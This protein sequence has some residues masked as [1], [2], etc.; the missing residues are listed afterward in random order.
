MTVSWTPPLLNISRDEV[1]LWNEAMS[2]SGERLSFEDGGELSFRPTVPPT[3]NPVTGSLK[4]V[5]FKEPLLVCIHHFPFAELFDVELPLADIE[6]LPSGLRAALYEG[7]LSWICD[8]AIPES[9]NYWKLKAVEQLENIPNPQT[10]EA[11]W[12]DFD[13]A[14]EGEYQIRL[15]L[16][17][18]RMDAVKVLR[19]LTLDPTSNHAILA[20]GVK[21]PADFIIGLITLTYR[22]LRSLVSGSVVVM[23][24]R[25]ADTCQMRIDDTLFTFVSTDDGWCCVDLGYI[26]GSVPGGMGDRIWDTRIMRDASTKTVSSVPIDGL[27]ITL[28]F[29]IGRKSLPVSELMQWRLGGLIDLSPPEIEG[30][31]EVTIRANGDVI[32]TGDL[33]QIDDRIAVRITRLIT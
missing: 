18:S 29:D 4:I 22:E 10:V 3:D 26:P 5:G 13:I 24:A 2:L 28:V 25:D 15:S 27:R 11:Q 20:Q 8:R 6:L 12:F 7:M 1:S 19:Q 30:G 23:A 17:L 14:A 16:S 33:I 9:R 31:L 32:G 21:A